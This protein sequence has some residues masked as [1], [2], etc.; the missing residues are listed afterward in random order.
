[1]IGHVHAAIWDRNFRGRG[2]PS[3]DIP[4]HALSALL[5]QE[6]T[7][8]DI[9]QLFGCSTKT[10]HRRIVRYGLS[11]FIQYTEISNEELDTLAKD[12]VTNFPTASQKTLAGHLSTLGYRI[13]RSRSERACIAL[14]RGELNKGVDVF[15]IAASTKS[16]AQ[17]AYG[18]STARNDGE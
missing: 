15:S 9:A 10:I 8:A 14:T 13:Q 11:R 1:M 16:P 3:L 2:R 6:F 5:E 7:Q 4:E 12:F 18:T 17:T